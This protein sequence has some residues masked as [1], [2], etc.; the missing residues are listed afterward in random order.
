LRP[1]RGCWGLPGVLCGDALVCQNV[2]IGARISGTGVIRLPDAHLDR[3]PLETRYQSNLL[4]AQGLTI[5]RLAMSQPYLP[6]WILTTALLEYYYERSGKC[7]ASAP[8]SK[9]VA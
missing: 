8:A 5:R 9:G 4:L 7:G 1:C 3:L 2:K 6:T